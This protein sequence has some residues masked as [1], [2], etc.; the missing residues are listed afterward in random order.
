MVALN[1]GGLAIIG[2]SV[3]AILWLFFGKDHNRSPRNNVCVAVV[4]GMVVIVYISMTSWTSSV[5][6]T[7]HGI[8]VG[9]IFFNDYKIVKRGNWG[10]RNQ[11]AEIERGMRNDQG[12]NRWL[13][14][15]LN[16]RGKIWWYHRWRYSHPMMMTMMISCHKWI[17]GCRIVS[18]PL[19]Q[20]SSKAA[21]VNS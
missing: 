2:D 1:N 12:K 20:A 17:T 5:V 9:V 18:S 15:S 21:S 19:E 6:S 8:V 4:F 16:R 14:W 3:G 7:Q 10:L 13:S 11:R